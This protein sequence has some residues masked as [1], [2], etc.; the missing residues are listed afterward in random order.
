MAGAAPAP[1]T[2]SREERAGELRRAGRQAAAGPGAPA[3]LGAPAICSHGARADPTARLAG[4]GSCRAGRA[5]H[6]DSSLLPAPH[7]VRRLGS[8]T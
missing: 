8:Q 6:S 2:R 4:A 7:P 1:R 5:L 3:A